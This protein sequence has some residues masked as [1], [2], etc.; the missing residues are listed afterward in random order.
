MIFMEL[1]K[2]I[3]NFLSVDWLKTLY[4]NAKVGGGD[5]PIY[6][7]RHTKIKS[8]K[9]LIIL[10]ECTYRG[11]IRIGEKC[12]GH[13]DRQSTPTI[14]NLTGGVLKFKGTAFLNQGTRINVSNKATL[15]FGDHFT[16]TGNSEILCENSITFGNHC[17]MSWNALVM[18]NDAHI[19]LN[20]YNEL[21]N[22]SRPIVIGNNVWIGCRTTILKGTTIADGSIIA[23]GSI[24]TKQFDESNCIIAGTGKQQT[25][26]AHN[27]TWKS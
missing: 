16:C 23:S 15:E 11:M 7:Y 26:I 8:M 4:I 20:E 3:S 14:V 24:I 2:R 17:L 25:V 18:D 13:I 10:P 27:R 5:L 1:L 22:P 12:L 6:I 9:G 19:I 21:V